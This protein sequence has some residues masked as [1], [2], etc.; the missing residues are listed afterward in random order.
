MIEENQSEELV[1]Y[2]IKKII[3]QLPVTRLLSSGNRYRVSG[4]K[5][6][7]VSRVSGIG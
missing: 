7:R 2:I 4:S 6:P 1:C 3:C 5:K